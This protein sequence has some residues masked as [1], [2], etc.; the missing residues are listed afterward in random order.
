VWPSAIW[1]RGAVMFEQALPWIAADDEE[2]YRLHAA[3][4]ADEQPRW[5]AATHHP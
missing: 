4:T 1:Y 2:E 3:D 5:A